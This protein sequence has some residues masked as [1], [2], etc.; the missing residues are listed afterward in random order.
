MS[1]ARHPVD[2]APGYLPGT[3]AAGTLPGTQTAVYSLN[4][5]MTQGFLRKRQGRTLLIDSG[6]KDFI[7]QA[8][9][10]DESPTPDDQLVDRFSEVDGYVIFVHGWTG[11]HHIWEHLPALLCLGNRRLVAISV[12]HNGFGQTTF[13]NDPPLEQCDPPAAMRALEG[14]I[15]LLGIRRARGDRHPKVINMVGHS[16][17]G[18]TLFYANPTVWNFG[19]YTRYALAPALLL[20]DEIKQAFYRALGLGIELV[21][22]IPA[23]EII[24]QLI[25][26]QIINVLC[27]GASDDTKEQHRAQYRATARGTT[28]ATFTAMGALR[29]RQIPRTFDLFRVM[30]GHRDPLVGLVPMLDLLSGLEFPPGHVR[31]VPGTHYMFSI[32]A[33][34]TYQHTQNRALVVQDILDLHA[35]ALA[36]QQ[37]GQRSG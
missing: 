23:F 27:A 18:A 12:D 16:M 11:N 35:R 3:R 17:G 13:V 28:A 8:T 31:V 19:E 4:R 6:L 33:D 36:M 26:P 20:E 21:N 1:V 37:S 10:A 15:N 5:L 9:W 7:W 30:L 14:W 22:R 32:G 2:W 25:K 29:D 24:E 34:S